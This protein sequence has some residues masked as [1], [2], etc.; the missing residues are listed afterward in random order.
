MSLC[1]YDTTATA[2]LSTYLNT[3]L[4]TK[5]HPGAGARCQRMV[6]LHSLDLVSRHFEFS[7]CKM[8]ISCII[9]CSRMALQQET[10]NCFFLL[11]PSSRSPSICLLLLLLS[12]LHLSLF[13]VPSFVRSLNADY[14]KMC[15][16]EKRGQERAKNLH[17]A[18]QVR[19][20]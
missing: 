8:N 19:G 2:V 11:L 13:F 16:K 20:D 7:L 4:M 12:F 9:R 6:Q 18:K 10:S 5:Q 1:Y 17:G 14:A 3:G 15:Q